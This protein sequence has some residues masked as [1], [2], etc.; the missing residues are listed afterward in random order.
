MVYRYAGEVFSRNPLR[1]V[2]QSTVDGKR[3]R[4]EA[5]RNKLV[6]AR[7]RDFHFEQVWS[8]YIARWQ[9]YERG[10]KSADRRMDRRLFAFI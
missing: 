4:L 5:F 9:S 2:V 6:D 1:S 7:R 3:Q 8:R 10:E